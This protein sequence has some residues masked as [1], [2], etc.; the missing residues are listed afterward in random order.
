MAVN[1]YT[2]LAVPAG[3]EAWMT[4]EARETHPGLPV[5]EV[6]ESNSSSVARSV[7]TKFSVS[8]CESFLSTELATGGRLTSIVRTP[9]AL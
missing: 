9:L 2:P 5:I 4:L 8:P 1:E 6:M 7:G 3:G